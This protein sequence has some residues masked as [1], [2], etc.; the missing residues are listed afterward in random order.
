MFS[1][2]SPRTNFVL[3]VLFALGAGLLMAGLL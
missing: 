2:S 1:D 3:R